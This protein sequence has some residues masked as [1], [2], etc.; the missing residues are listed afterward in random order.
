MAAWERSS[1]VLLSQNSDG[2]EGSDA[3]RHASSLEQRLVLAEARTLDILSALEQL[4]MSRAAP[5][6]LQPQP[7]PALHSVDEE[8]EGDC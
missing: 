4:L 5:G 8:N 2:A 6:S 3:S 7:S 1:N